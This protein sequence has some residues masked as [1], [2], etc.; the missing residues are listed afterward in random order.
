MQRKAPY[1]QHEQKLSLTEFTGYRGKSTSDY[2]STRT[3][4]SE[5][6]DEPA[7]DI[8][9]FPCSWTLATQH[10]RV[11]TWQSAAVTITHYYRRCRDDGLIA[12]RTALTIPDATTPARCDTRYLTI[13]SWC[14]SGNC[15]SHFLRSARI[16]ISRD[17]FSV[18]CSRLLNCFM[19][20][21]LSPT[22]RP[23]TMTSMTISMSLS[24][25]TAGLILLMKFKRER[26]S[27][28]D[29]TDQSYS[30]YVG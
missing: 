30:Y 5:L 13:N 4:T 20:Q 22:P 12:S 16:S 9:A 2:Y 25:T 19:N 14:S 24:T 28:T 21:L 11:W 6:L 8:S 1:R 10:P 23:G 17:V 7:T 15:W 26:T 3:Y 18:C 29:D 27:S